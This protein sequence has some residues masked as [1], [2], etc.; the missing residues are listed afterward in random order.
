MYISEGTAR[1]I[2]RETGAAR[3]S[4]D[5]VAEFHKHINK[6]AFEVASKAVRLSLHAK[7]KTVGA[8]DIKLACG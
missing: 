7:R 1:R 5:A 6:A 2:L 3:V 4:S 8:S